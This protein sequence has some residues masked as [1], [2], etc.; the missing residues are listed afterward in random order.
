[1][2]EMKAYEKLTPRG[3]LRRTRRIAQAALKAFGFPEAR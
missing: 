1:M 2:D 3:K